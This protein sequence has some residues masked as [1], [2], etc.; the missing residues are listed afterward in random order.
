MRTPASPAP[1]GKKQALPSYLSNIR[2]AQA[3]L[4]SEFKPFLSPAVS[5]ADRKTTRPQAPTGGLSSSTSGRSTI[6]RTP[7]K[8]AASIQNFG[9]RF[10]DQWRKRRRKKGSGNVSVPQAFYVSVACFFFAFPLFFVLFIL[11]RHAVFGDESLTVTSRHE[12]PLHTSDEAMVSDPSPIE[13]IEE[14]AGLNDNAKTVPGEGRD[15]A[16]GSDSTNVSVENEHPNSKPG[17]DAME[18]KETASDQTDATIAETSSILSSETVKGDV[19]APN[20]TGLVATNRTQI[21]SNETIQL[22]EVEKA[23]I[24]SEQKKM[25][26]GMDEVAAG[27]AS[28]SSKIDEKDRAGESG[29]VNPSKVDTKTKSRLRSN[30]GSAGEASE[31]EQ[32][33]ILRGKSY[34]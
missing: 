2:N 20:A 4:D 14:L 15:D 33:R 25:A 27:I 32:R 24:L 28:R 34:R 13:V 6:N 22:D 29:K 1:K 10:G 3:R 17:A 11:A 31:G 5:T 9:Q 16:D 19:G 26:F 12:V 23:Q 30:D 7:S 8:W 18:N 21:M